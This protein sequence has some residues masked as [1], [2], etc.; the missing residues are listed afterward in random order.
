MKHAMMEISYLEMD[1]M[2]SVM[3]NQGGFEKLYRL[4]F[5]QRYEEME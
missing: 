5:A 1:A 4:Q 2:E 3:K